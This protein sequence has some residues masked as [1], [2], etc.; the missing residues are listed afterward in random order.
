MPDFRCNDKR[1]EAYV[2]IFKQFPS[3]FITCAFQIYR[4]M[5]PLNAE[6]LL[7][8]G[9]RFLT[10]MNYIVAMHSNQIREF[11]WRNHHIIFVFH[12]KWRFAHFIAMNRWN[13]MKTDE[14]WMLQPDSD[15][16]VESPTT[17]QQK[18]S[19]KR[20]ASSSSKPMK[21][22]E[23]PRKGANRNASIKKICR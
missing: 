5:L 4:L 10:K 8:G 23:S 2:H 18:N 13:L 11:V 6:S 9:S 22:P 1:Y 14:I 3:T 21:E 16:V 7:N 15:T 17:L 12:S 20:V 19:R